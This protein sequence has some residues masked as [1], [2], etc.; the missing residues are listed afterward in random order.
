MLAS[1]WRVFAA[2]WRGHVL[3][4]LAGWVGLATARYSLEAEPPTLVS[5]VIQ[6]AGYASIFF[7]LV[8]VNCRTGEKEKLGDR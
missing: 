6:T 8:F 2:S 4:C 5:A 1:K 7:L 3:N